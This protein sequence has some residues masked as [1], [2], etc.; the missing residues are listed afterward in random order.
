MAQFVYIFIF[1]ICVLI[2][3]VL[4]Q[5]HQFRIDTEFS[6]KV[7]KNYLAINRQPP[8]RSL[9]RCTARCDRCCH[10]FGF[11]TR[12]IICCAFK[13]CDQGNLIGNDEGW[14]YYHSNELGELNVY[15]NV[16]ALRFFRTIGNLISRHG[17][18]IK[19]FKSYNTFILYNTKTSNNINE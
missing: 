8:A 14:I 18:F 7:L 11:N 12:S 4:G 3:P 1:W 16:Q 5:Y 17:Q 13:T 10:C 19:A 2:E 9:L 15:Y 6:N